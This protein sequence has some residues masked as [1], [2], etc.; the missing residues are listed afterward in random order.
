MCRVKDEKV[1]DKCPQDFNGKT[2]YSIAASHLIDKNPKDIFLDLLESSDQ[3]PCNI[4]SSNDHLEVCRL[5]LETFFED[6]VR[7]PFQL[8]AWNGHLSVI[9]E[10]QN[11]PLREE[12]QEI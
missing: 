4:A 11:I 9:N 2:P 12:Y 5:F 1:D 3:K 8:A 6:G 10:R 7:T